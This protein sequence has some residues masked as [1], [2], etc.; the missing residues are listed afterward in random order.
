MIDKAIS[1]NPLTVLDCGAGWGEI[2]YSIANHGIHVIALTPCPSSVR[3]LSKVTAEEGLSVEILGGLLEECDFGDRKFDVVLC[4]EVI[5]HVANDMT[6]IEKAISLASR[7]VIVTTPF[8]SVERGFLGSKNDHAKVR[9]QHVRAYSEKRFN[10]LVDHAEKSGLVKS[11]GVEAVEGIR[12]LVGD[13]VKSFCSVLEV[14]SDAGVKHQDF[15]SGR[16][17]G[18]TKV[19]KHSKKGKARKQKGQPA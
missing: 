9:G 2:A 10:L 12:N 19:A 3:Y 17:S 13:P 15:G 7:A 14:I 1:Y 8:G 11:K 16:D 18:A 4:G 5:E 6:F